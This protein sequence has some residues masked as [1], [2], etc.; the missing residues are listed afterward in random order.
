MIEVEALIKEMQEVKAE[1]PSLSI[2]EV[3]KIFE[4]KSMRDLISAIERA[5]MSND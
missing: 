1:Y 4:I 5:R 3:L 2:A